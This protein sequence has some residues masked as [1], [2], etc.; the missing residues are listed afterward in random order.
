LPNQPLNVT[1]RASKKGEVVLL[2]RKLGKL[3]PRLA[4]DPQ[5]AAATVDA[6]D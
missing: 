4:E 3:G 5:D 6:A 2:M 1:V